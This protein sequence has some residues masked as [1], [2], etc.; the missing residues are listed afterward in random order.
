MPGKASS[1]TMKFD[2]N[3]FVLGSRPGRN[4]GSDM[5]PAWDV[6]CGFVSRIIQLH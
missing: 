5:E 1:K 3:S 2:S 6:A 4:T